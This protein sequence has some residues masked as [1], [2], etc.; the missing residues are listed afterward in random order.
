[1]TSIE[2]LEREFPPA[3]AAM[4]ARLAPRVTS[5]EVEGE[6]TTLR[7]APTGVARDTT[8]SPAELIVRSDRRTI[9]DVV[10]GEVTLV[11]AVLQDRLAVQGHPDD[12]V[13]FH[14][15]LLLFV[16]GAVRSPSFPSLLDAFRHAPCRRTDV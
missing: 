6:R 2:A 4:C 8:Q 11:D 15:A 3:Y 1:M 12:L 10:D 13:A 14:D 16:H 5:I 9:L 7:F